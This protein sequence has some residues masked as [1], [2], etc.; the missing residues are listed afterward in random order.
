MLLKTVAYDLAL[1]NECGKWI[2]YKRVDGLPRNCPR[3]GVPSDV[4]ISAQ[5][6]QRMEE[7]QQREQFIR[8]HGNNQSFN[9]RFG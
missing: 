4:S 7:A 3:C 2:I 1:C 8:N 5:D 9:I 6:R